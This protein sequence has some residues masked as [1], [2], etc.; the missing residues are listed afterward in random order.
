MR[1]SRFSEEK[2]IAILAEQ[3]RGMG[4]AEVCRKHGISSAAFYKWKAK[5]GGMDV[6]EARKGSISAAQFLQRFVDHT[7]WAHIDIAGTAAEMGSPAIAIN[8]GW[9]SGFGV[10][11]LNRFVA[12]HFENVTVKRDRGS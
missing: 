9:A 8:Q 7:P 10:R 2:I 4:T 3:E 5:F 6:S 1:Q 11:L 12:E